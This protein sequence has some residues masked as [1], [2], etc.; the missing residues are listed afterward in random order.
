MNGYRCKI[1]AGAVHLED[2][3]GGVVRDRG[4][5]GV[6]GGYGIGFPIIIEFQ[7]SARFHGEIFDEGHEILESQ[8]R[9]DAQILV[10]V[11]LDN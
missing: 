10:L 8:T 11:E 7:V 3:G 4:I 1:E 9:L 6:S 5:G 2:P